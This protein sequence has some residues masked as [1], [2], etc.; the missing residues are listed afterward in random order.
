M[1][2]TP[3]AP[4]RCVP[5][6]KLPAR[7]SAYDLL[8]DGQALRRRLTLVTADVGEFARVRGLAWRDWAAPR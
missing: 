2:R 8:I 1:M 7:R 6:W 4:A 3:A 5:R